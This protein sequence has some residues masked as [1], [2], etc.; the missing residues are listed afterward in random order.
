MHTEYPVFTF[1]KKG[2]YIAYYIVRPI[3]DKVN[4]YNEGFVDI[5]NHIQTFV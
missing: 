5:W 2:L 4:V 1:L 3:L